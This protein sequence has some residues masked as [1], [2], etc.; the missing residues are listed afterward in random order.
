MARLAGLLLLI[1]LL[2][3]PLS[4]RAQS[5][6]PAWYL[7]ARA[8]LS[9]SSDHSDPPGY[10]VY[11]AITVEGAA[12]R[13]LG[14]WLGVEL[15]ARTESHE[16]DLTQD[17]GY[18]SLGSVEMLPINLLLELRPPWWRRVHPYLGA[19]VNV[20][21]TWEKS[22]EL[23]S[24]DLTPSVGPAV[25]LGVDVNLSSALFVNADVRW[26]LLRTTIEQNGERIAALRIDPLS[27]GIGLGARF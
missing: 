23:D 14:R 21:V 26:N 1:A 10:E 19:G 5:V 18:R 24:T 16:I 12:G 2:L 7:A 13:H 11:S 25:G 15:D 9:G 27:L 20:T 17:A 3:V 4:A 6:A 22:G 8:V